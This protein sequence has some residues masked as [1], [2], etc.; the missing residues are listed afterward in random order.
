MAKKVTK[1]QAEEALNEEAK[2]V[3]LDQVETIVAK[4]DKFKE[5]FKHVKVLS[6]YWDDVCLALAMTKDYMTG[7]YKKCPWRTIASII[8]ALVYVLSPLDLIPD[9][10][11]VLGWTDDVTVL[12]TALKFISDDLEEYKK[13]RKEIDSAASRIERLS[14]K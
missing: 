2:K 3:S 13:T 12:A 10:I 1:A 5:L 4:T 7:T 11:P 8:G 6:R 14:I 9:F